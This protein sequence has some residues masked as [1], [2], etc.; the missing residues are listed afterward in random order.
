[1]TTLTRR[2]TGDVRAT[3]AERRQFLQVAGGIT[4]AVTLLLV[5]LANRAADGHLVYVIDDPAIHMSM[6]RQLAQHGTWGVTSGVYEPASSSPMWTAM[7][8]AISWLIPSSLNVLPLALNAIAAAVVLWI[9]ASYQTFVTPRRGNPVSYLATLA[10]PVVLLFLPGLIMLG[11]EHVLHSVLVL[12]AAVLLIR[13][14]ATELDL[15]S[16][17]PLLGVLFIAGT[18][19]VETVFFALGIAI[20][21]VV[22][23][24]A[25]FT[26]ADISW[27]R[28]A[29][30]RTG[31]LAI[32]VS[33]LP[34]MIYGAVNRAFGRSFL[35][36]SVIAKAAQAE[37][38]ILRSPG[39]A[40]EAIVSDPILVI[41]G[42]AAIAY[43]AWVGISGR[44]AHVIPAVTLVVALIA[45]SEWGEIG[46]WNRY[47]M[48]LIMLGTL[49]ICRMASE[50]AVGAVLRPTLLVF[51]LTFAAVSTGRVALTI[52]TPLASSNTY[53]QRYQLGKFFAA[54]YQNQPVAT[55]ELGYATLFHDGPVVDLLGLGTYE[56]AI[57]MRDHSGTIPAATV[58][59]LLRENHVR[60][61]GVYPAT[62]NVAKPPNALWHAGRWRLT[63]S[64]ASAFQDSVDFFTP[65]RRYQREL[66]RKLARYAHHLPSHVK[67]LDRNA[68]LA[69]FFKHPP[70]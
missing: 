58:A 27:S 3:A 19:R 12:I 68:L 33:A 9:F 57:Q 66:S 31:V 43:L 67:Y 47:Q 22:R 44:S 38:G 56:V 53:R 34:F 20:A 7:L 35:P 28:R 70:K 17:A 51:L 11:M 13:L 65:G 59:K 15:R 5:V 37:R 40:L 14:E 48:Y 60:A 30:L 1:M 50:V 29:A 4:V 8:A 10:M 45:Q 16:T 55:G 42:L 52:S 41:F 63:E 36:N 49:M 46:W 69:D 64:N 25:R 26:T 2:V 61:I 54:E 62:F 21:L 18:V 6:A 39:K 32:G 24:T 23:R